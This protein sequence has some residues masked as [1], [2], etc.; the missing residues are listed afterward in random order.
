MHGHHVA[1]APRAPPGSDALPS[2]CQ[3]LCVLPCFLLQLTPLQHT[4][5]AARMQQQ[6][7]AAATA[8]SAVA[9]GQQCCG[10]WEKPRGGQTAEAGLRS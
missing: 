3:Q 10:L 1:A 5:A 9:A 4:A 7:P 2:H 6:P 8:P